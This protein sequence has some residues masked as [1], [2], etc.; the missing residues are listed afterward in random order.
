MN[1][2]GP[3]AAI[4]DLREAEG[5]RIAVATRVK[6]YASYDDG[7][8]SAGVLGSVPAWQGGAT[9]PAI[10]RSAGGYLD[11]DE[12]VSHSMHA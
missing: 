11:A 12:T 7:P 4:D 10:G 6:R 2:V 8:S 9:G 5:E 1:D 3:G